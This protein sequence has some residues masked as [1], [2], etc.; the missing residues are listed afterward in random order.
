MGSSNM[1]DPQKKK[2]DYYKM[3]IFRNVGVVFLAFEEHQNL[4]WANH[5]TH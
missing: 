4:Y 3:I 1:Q 5:F 2:K